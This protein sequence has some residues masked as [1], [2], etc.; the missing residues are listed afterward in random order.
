M[1]RNPD[2]TGNRNNTVSHEFLIEDVTIFR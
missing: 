2:K 1:R